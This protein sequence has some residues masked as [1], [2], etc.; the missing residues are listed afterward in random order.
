MKTRI[1]IFGNGELDSKLLAEISSRDF[2]IGVDYGAYWLLKHK[3]IPQVAIGDFDSVSEEELQVIRKEIGEVREYE[4]EKDATDMDLA[5]DFAI[6]KKPTEIILFGA[7]G[8]RLDQT[9][10]NI[11]LLEKIADAGIQGWIKDAHNWVTVVS[12]NIII[13]RQLFEK[14]TLRAIRQ[15]AE[16]RE[17]TKKK[18]STSLEQKE[19]SHF[20]D[21]YVSIIP[22]TKTAKVT[23]KGFK[24]P[25]TAQKM[26]RGKT[27]GISNEL[28]SSSGTISVKQ[29]RVFV[30]LSKKDTLL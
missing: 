20:E 6:S 8:R 12:K 19:N 15:Q 25:I 13:S 30:V 29:G 18:F 3:I 23:L 14:N 10:A 28:T 22:L 1:V 26:E 7:L 21:W 27:L 5:V 9:L 16:S 4:K 24:Y 2:V 17:V 11:G